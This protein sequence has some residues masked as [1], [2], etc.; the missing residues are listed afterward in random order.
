MTEYFLLEMRAITKRFPGVVA[1]EGVD[2]D[3]KPGEVH[4]LVGENGAG[5]STLMKILSGAYQPDAGEVR[6]DGR[7]VRVGSP[8]A[9]IALGIGTIYQEFTLLPPFS[10]AENIFLGREPS[11]RRWLGVV[12]FDRMLRE[13]RAVLDLLGLPI[14]P[15]MPAGALSVA[16]QQL[17]EVAKAI[18]TKARLLIFDEPT[19]ALADREV[20]H[21]FGLIR[22][23]RDQGVGVVYISHRLGEI[24]D[25]GDRVT[26]LRDG[27][28][29]G[30]WPARDLDMGGL[31]RAMAGREIREVQHRSRLRGAEV[32]G[33][34]GLVRRGVLDDV[35]LT[36]HEGEVVGLAGLVGS[37][38]TE[39]ARAIVGADPLDGG[40]VRIAGEEIRRPSCRLS[41]RRGLGLLPEDRKLHGLVLVAPVR[42]NISLAS[43]SRLHRWGWLRRGEERRLAAT[44]V[45]HLRIRTPDVERRVRFL[46]GG[47][48]QKVVLAKWLCSR[49]RALIFDEPTRGIDVG[50]KA[51]I[52]DLIESLADGGAGILVISS[53]LPELLRLCDRILV[54]RRGRIVGEVGRDEATQEKILAYAFGAPAAS[55]PAGTA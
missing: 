12:D 38:R 55:A 41:V 7:V 52:Y 51:E 26:V 36:V 5:K 18:S 15:A 28:R 49:A 39:L 2:F 45:A 10:V 34:R 17:V 54:M 3:L 30:T 16:Q 40:V 42:E 32:L 14:D 6:L 37:G 11:G 22:R 13:A 20:R 21:L 1:L 46:S 44:Q 19:A 50:A 29:I 53:D 8:R 24:P 25:I 27:R 48:Q 33:V 47:N 9:A 31:V 4:V 35:D 23:L 43:L